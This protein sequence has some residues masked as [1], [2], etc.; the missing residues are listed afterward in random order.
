MGE[1]VPVSF[2][3]PVAV[4]G[5]APVS[6]TCSPT[7]GATLPL[8]THQVTCNAE[9]TRG[10]RATCGFAVTVRAI[11]RLE[12]T[13][14]LTYGDS[15]TEGKLSLT[16]S[17]LVD[18]PSHSYPAK[19]TTLLRDRYTSQDITV[20]NEGFGGER[21]S[22]S[23]PRFRGAL[24][25]HRPE[26]VLLM[27][28]VN[29]INATL[30]PGI[31]GTANAIEELIKE[32]V[33]SGHATFVATLPPLGPGPKAFCTDCVEPLNDLIRDLAAAKGAVLVD[34]YAAWGDRTDLMGADGIHPNEAG[35]Q[36]IAEAFFAA[37][38]RHLEIDLPSP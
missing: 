21:A 35:Y 27:H 9:D 17:L 29:D 3:A 1:P 24:S 2:T 37:I 14:F 8:G 38:R 18:S 22:E 16:V 26:A 10:Q 31:Q 12:R 25:T 5:T 19:L 28:G 7:S 4:G 23:Y 15:L 6:V 34:V 13:R 20:F 30:L 36:V 33:R 32:S 11:P